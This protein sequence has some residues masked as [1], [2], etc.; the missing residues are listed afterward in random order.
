MDEILSQN[1]SEA[2]SQSE[3][4]RSRANSFPGQIYP[5]QNFNLKN[6]NKKESLII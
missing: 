6:K 4:E 3:I 5:N 1:K 2:V